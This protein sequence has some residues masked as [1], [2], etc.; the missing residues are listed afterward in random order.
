M[1][2]FRL[3]MSSWPWSYF[4]VLATAAFLS[5]SAGTFNRL[6][7]GPNGQRVLHLPPWTYSSTPGHL[8]AVLLALIGV[9]AMWAALIYGL[10]VAK[11][12]VVLAMLIGAWL[13]AFICSAVLP[14]KNPTLRLFFAYALA[15]A[16]LIFHCAGR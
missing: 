13:L 16:A 2:R 5:D 3:L 10:F 14:T 1:K 7:S 6:L 4:A 15:A 11:W 12:Y 8:S 9:L